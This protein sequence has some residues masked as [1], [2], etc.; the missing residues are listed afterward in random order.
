[1]GRSRKGQGEG[2]P[3]GA[4]RSSARGASPLLVALGEVLV[5]ERVRLGLCQADIARD[6]GIGQP[7]LSRIERGLV[8]LSV[9]TLAAL[10]GLFNGRLG[11]RSD[12]AA[13]VRLLE[14]AFRALLDDFPLADRA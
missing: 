3:D 8:S 7:Q 6:L 11:A 12:A 5:R 10:G 14:A 9:E 4:R 13:T 2:E 1:M